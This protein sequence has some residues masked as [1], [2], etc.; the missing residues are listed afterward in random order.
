MTLYVR[1]ANIFTPTDDGNL[2][3]RDKLPAGN[4]IVKRTPDGDWFFEKVDSFQINFKLYGDTLPNT[5][6]IL[7]TFNNREAATGVMLTGEK[8]S[9]K[10]LLAKSLSIEAAKQDMPTLIINT[11][12]FGDSFNKLIQDIHQPCVVLFD[13]FEKIYDREDQ[14]KMLTLLD[15]VFPTKKLFVL[16]C[17]DKWRVDRHLRN[18]P[19]RIHYLINYGGVSTEFIHEYCND[20]LLNLQY[21]DH[22]CKLT[23]AFNT[24]NFD[25][26]KALVAE[27]NM[28][29]EAPD[30]ALKMLNINPE[31]ADDCRFKAHFTPAETKET[32]ISN[33]GGNPLTE[34]LEFSYRDSEGDWI[35]IEFNASDLSSF[36]NSG[37]SFEDEHGNKLTMARIV[38]PPFSFYDAF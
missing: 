17:N 21:V 38:K 11:P 5:T 7:N 12:W 18:R 6:R 22:I 25:M 32:S 13:E 29:N 10:S 14:Q 23:S 15:G 35:E 1:R 36:D 26:L 37:Y 27:M 28:Y 20:N 33:W 34:S 8:G 9:G 31:D 16:T 3:V 4:F 19:G 2:D 30:H 24:F